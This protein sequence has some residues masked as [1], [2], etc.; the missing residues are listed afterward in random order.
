MTRELNVARPLDPDVRSA[1]V[2]LQQGA[3]RARAVHVVAELGIPDLVA[4]GPKTVDEL[5]AATKTHAPSLGRLLRATST[6]G[7]LERLADGQTYAQTPL[8][9]LLCREPANPESA[10][11]LF[12]SAPW[13]W[14]AWGELLHSVRT[15]EASF[16]VANGSSFWEL[17]RQDPDAKARFNAAMS[18]VSVEECD[19]V[20]RAY[21]FSD[22]LTVVDVA[23]GLGSLLGSVLRHYPGVHGTLLERPD[24]LPLAKDLLATQGVDG[25]YDIVAGDFFESV[26]EGADVYLIKRALHDWES[27]DI[28]RIL[29]RIKAAM[30]PDS[31]LLVIEGVLD[32]DSTQDTLFRDLLLLVLVGGREYAVQEYRDVIT[33]AGLH[34]RRTVPTGVGPLTI[35][36]ATR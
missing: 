34:V 36:E 7:V 11:A 25:R 13:H 26:P 19:A 1:M 32:D 23:G 27:D 30:R 29:E 31:R 8:S 21:D 16:D 6:Y 24:V 5:A 2:E 15:G 10:D 3:W 18:T 28:V 14:R 20:A 22:V 35:I 4:D 33:R 12:Q 17:T 9:G